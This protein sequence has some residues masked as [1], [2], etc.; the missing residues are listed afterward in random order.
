MRPDKFLAGFL[1]EVFV[2]VTAQAVFVCNLAGHANEDGLVLG[3]VVD[4]IHSGMLPWVYMGA[5]GE[6][7]LH[8]LFLL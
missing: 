6:Q 3:Q 2:C 8:L 7:S 4:D 1:G 5:A